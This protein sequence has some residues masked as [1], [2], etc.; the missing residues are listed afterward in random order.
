MMVIITKRNKQWKH[1]E[2]KPFLSF[3]L[4]LL[5][6]DFLVYQHA[7]YAMWFGFIVSAISVIGNDSIQTLGT[8]IASNKKI[9]WFKLQAFVG[10]ILVATLLWGWFINDGSLSFGRLSSIPQPKEFNFL[11]LACPIFLLIMTYFRMPV[12]TTFLL[13]S[14]FSGQLV[15]QKMLIKSMLGYLVAFMVAY[16]LWLMIHFFFARG[17]LYNKKNYSKKL[18]RLFQFIITGFLWSLWIMHDMANIVVFLPRQLSLV[19]M[20][21]ALSVLF[22][23]SAIILKLRGGNIQ[24]IVN[25]KTCVKDV[26]AATIIDLAYVFLLIVFKNINQVPMS[27]TWVFIGLLAG[28]E[29]AFRTGKSPKKFSK[30]IKM[31]LVDFSR[32]SI[33][34]VFSICIALIV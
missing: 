16:G 27:T 26:R 29:M 10:G 6:I 22:I 30:G 13:L 15:L 12:S 28:R 25:K 17:R 19:E 3:V 31:L 23:T 5:L 7:S 8:F 2:R 24:S 21:T 4:S 9:H 1:F 32:A 20:L 33:G 34:L 14:V 11:E 18:W